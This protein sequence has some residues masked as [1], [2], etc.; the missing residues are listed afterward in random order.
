MRIDSAGP[1][2]TFA[3]V[4]DVNDLK[5]DLAVR[6]AFHRR[7]RELGFHLHFTDSRGCVGLQAAAFLLSITRPH[8]TK[9]GPCLTEARL[10]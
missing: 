6:L 7:T 10:D 2:R 1:M 5:M 4:V 8:R 9:A 3:V